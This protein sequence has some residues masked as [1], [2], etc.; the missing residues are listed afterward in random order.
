M[1]EEKSKEKN[2]NLINYRWVINDEILDLCEEIN[3][4]ILPSAYFL[5]E[6]YNSDKKKEFIT[7]SKT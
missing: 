1:Y 4:E 7:K 3:T 5:S 6:Y 2:K